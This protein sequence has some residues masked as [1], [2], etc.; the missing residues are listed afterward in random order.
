[1][2]EHPPKHANA[3]DNFFARGLVLASWL[4][5]GFCALLISVGASLKP[6]DLGWETSPAALAQADTGGDA[7]PDAKPADAKPGAPAAQPKKLSAMREDS[8]S[9]WW[10]RSVSFLGIFVMIG[11]A[12]LVGGLRKDVKWK[13]V[14]VGTV[15]QIVFAALIFFN[16]R[17]PNSIMGGNWPAWMPVPRD[18][19]DVFNDAFIRLLGFTAQGSKFLFGSFVFQGEVQPQLINFAFGVLPTI[20]FFSSFMTVLYHLGIMEQIV[21]F[22]G[23]IMVRAMGTSGAESLSA[24]ANIFVGQTEAPVVVKPFIEKMTQ[25][26]LMAIMTGGF[27]TVAGGVMALYVGALQEVFPDIAGHLVAASVM[28]APAGL[29]MAKLIVPETEVPETMGKLDLRLEKPDANVIEAASRGAS[30]GLQLAFN[31]AGMLLA[32]IAL[33]ALL[34]FFVGLPS[35][36]HNEGELETLVEYFKAKAL[37]VPEGCAPA[38]DE[39]LLSCIDQM[40]VAAGAPAVDPWPALTMQKLVG[41]LFWPLAW[42]MGTPTQDCLIVAQMLGTKTV[43]NELVAYL[44]LGAILRDPNTQISHRA[45]VITTYALCGFSNFSSIAIQIGGLGSLA[46]NRRSDLARLGLRAMVAGSLACFQTAT[47]AGILI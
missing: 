46:P 43:V 30:E 4:L 34:N 41:Y 32:F 13:P 24:S 27:A 19:F 10:E 18:I 14:I 21:K 45:A 26:E 29:V 33:I 23:W 44:D 42:V 17:D 12:W 15:L 25:S 16:P 31:V 36:W 1:M 7:K 38:S 6:G 20:I 8:G 39:K 35:L 11:L 22:F 3:R 47:I 9:P 37:V 5:V 28:S 40:R 2:L